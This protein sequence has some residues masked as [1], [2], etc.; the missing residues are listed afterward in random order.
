MSLS[1]GGSKS[2]Q[3]QETS[4]SF[5]QTQDTRLSDRAYNAFT[6]RMGDLNAREYQQLDPGS[7]DQW[8][9][10]YQQQVVDA[11]LAN[12]NADRTQAR[13][14]LQADWAK[15][16]AFGNDRRGI[17]EA[18]LEGQFDRTTASTLAAL[19]SRGYEQALG[20]AQGEN[21]NANAYDQNTQQMLNQLLMMLGNET[22]SNTR[23]SSKGLSKGSGSQFGFSAGYGNGNGGK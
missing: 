12:I 20:V 15:A 18:E 3:R 5:N 9:N 6:D 1:F 8:M 2:K 21:T 11:T 13:T 19:N 7:V 10:P 14:G 4:Q 16:G 22:T 23:G 17:A